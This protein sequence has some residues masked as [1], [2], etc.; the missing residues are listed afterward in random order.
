MLGPS[1]WAKA[2]SI[3]QENM[4]KRE[5]TRVV[6]EKWKQMRFGW[7]ERGRDVHEVEEGRW[8]WPGLLLSA[9]CW[10]DRQGVMGLFVI[11]LTL[12]APAFGRLSNDFLSPQTG[13]ALCLAPLHSTGDLANFLGLLRNGNGDSPH[14]PIH[15]PSCLHTVFSHQQTWNLVVGLKIWYISGRVGSGHYFHLQIKAQTTLS[16]IQS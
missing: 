14:P 6:K 7:W 10:V 13:L 15:H 9:E 16:S 1:V 5:G 2:L 8:G 12:V 3:K 11:S 4:P